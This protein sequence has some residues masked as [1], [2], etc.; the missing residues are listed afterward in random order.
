LKKKS[1]FSEKRR[2]AFAKRQSQ[3]SSLNPA[4]A[5]WIEE[6]IVPALANKYFTEHL[7]EEQ[8]DA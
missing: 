2:E 5:A 3:K 7:M 8:R 1:V 4:I 6:V